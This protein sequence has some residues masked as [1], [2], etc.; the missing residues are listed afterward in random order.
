MPQAPTAVTIAQY[1]VVA[2]VLAAPFQSPLKGF[3]FET[4]ARAVRCST[5]GNETGQRRIPQNNFKIYRM[6]LLTEG[7]KNR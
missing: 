4:V 7:K 1:A 3:I 5:A 2:A 6:T